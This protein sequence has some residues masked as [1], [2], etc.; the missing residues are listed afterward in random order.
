VNLEASEKRGQKMAEDKWDERGGPAPSNQ[1][2]A[3]EGILSQ[4]HGLGGL[5]VVAFIAPVG[6][7]ANQ[8]YGG[9][10]G[11]GPAARV[12]ALDL[13]AKL[14]QGREETQARIAAEREALAKKA[15]GT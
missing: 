1:A 2:S 13:V 5:L 4:C 12:L 14:S 9:A 15:S 11:G 3:V 7:S 8:A 10:P 6:G